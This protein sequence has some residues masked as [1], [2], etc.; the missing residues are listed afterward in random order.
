MTHKRRNRVPPD[1]VIHGVSA[2]AWAK[3]WGIEIPEPP[4]CYDCNR[5]RS[6]TLPFVRGVF[7][8]LKAPTCECGNERGPW[9]IVH[10]RGLVFEDW[11]DLTGR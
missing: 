9:C 2:E 6:L 1:L 11:K 10:A 8:G 5:P 7:R 4:E 3:R